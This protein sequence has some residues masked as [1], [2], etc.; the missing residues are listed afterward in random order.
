MKKMMIFVIPAIL[1]ALIFTYRDVMFINRN[2]QPVDDGYWSDKETYGLNVD[3]V[4]DENI[5]VENTETDEITEDDELTE[6]ENMEDETFTEE[7]FAEENSGNVTDDVLSEDTN[8]REPS[9]SSVISNS[10]KKTNGISKK[11]T[12]SNTKSPSNTK[13][14]SANGAENVSNTFIANE[15]YIPSKK[16]KENTCISVKKLA[17]VTTEDFRYNGIIFNKIDDSNAS[18]NFMS[19]ENRKDYGIRMN[20]HL[21]FYDKYKN[22]IGEYQK[23]KNT[24]KVSKINTNDLIDQ[25][26]MGAKEV[27]G[28]SCNTIS[29]FLED[30]HKVS[31]VKYYKVVELENIEKETSSSKKKKNSTKETKSEESE[32]AETDTTE[33]SAQSSKTE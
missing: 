15:L 14:T 17:D 32:Q 33:V 18:L 23:E 1:F 13:K 25:S 21:I 3:E 28:G 19:V 12:V 11:N 20:I 27:I 6:T 2:A 29:D 16:Y 24:K 10:N 8:N 9:N 31:E 4:V 30:G 26:Y 7:N 5:E 22:Q